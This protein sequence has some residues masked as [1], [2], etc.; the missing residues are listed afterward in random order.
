[1]EGFEPRHAQAARPQ[2]CDIFERGSLLV[3]AGTGGGQEPSLPHDWPCSP[4]FES[5]KSLL[6]SIRHANLQDQLLKK[7]IPRVKAW[8]KPEPLAEQ[9]VRAMAG[10]LFCKRLFELLGRPQAGSS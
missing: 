4:R 9:V 1:L 7:D 8:L 2:L 5:G 3:E 6:V 10:R